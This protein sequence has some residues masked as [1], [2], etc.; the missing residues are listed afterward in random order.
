MNDREK[1]LIYDALCEVLLIAQEKGG[2][3][4]CNYS[5]DEIRRLANKVTLLN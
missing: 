3:Y 5:V 4:Q 2:F 1:Q